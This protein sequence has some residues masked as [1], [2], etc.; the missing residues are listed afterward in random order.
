MIFLS[1]NAQIITEKRNIRF[2]TIAL[3]AMDKKPFKLSKSDILT[4]IKW[5]YSVIRAFETVIASHVAC[6]VRM[7]PFSVAYVIIVVGCVGPFLLG[8]HINDGPRHI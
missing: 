1:K 8:A 3:N 4:K 2:S 5:Y 6:F 7:C